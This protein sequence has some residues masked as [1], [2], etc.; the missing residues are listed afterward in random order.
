MGRFT[1]C[2]YIFRGSYLGAMVAIKKGT[3]GPKPSKPGRQ[4]IGTGSKFTEE[5]T[6][7]K[8]GRRV[9][10]P[11]VEVQEEDQFPT[12]PIV[13]KPQMGLEEAPSAPSKEVDSKINPSTE[14][15]RKEPLKKERIE[16]LS[17]KRQLKYQL[18]RERSQQ[19]SR[20][21]NS[22][23]GTL[24]C[25]RIGL[26]SHQ[27][28][29]ESLRINPAPKVVSKVEPKPL[30][31]MLPLPDSGE[32][33]S[34]TAAERMIPFEIKASQG[35]HYLVKLVNTDT[36]TDILT[37]FVRSGSTAEIDVPLGT[38]E[39]KFA[40]GEAWYGDKHL[41][42]PKTVC[43]K[44]DRTFKFDM[45]GDHLRGHSITLYKVPHGNLHISTIPPQSFELCT[46]NNHEQTP[47]PSQE[48]NL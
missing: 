31:P 3:K 15:V 7:S 12:G 45:V 10:G 1:M 36:H 35:S 8:P 21:E 40:C 37:V 11:G 43:S 5:I 2:D 46:S 41:F 13:W 30:I 27:E 18:V 6:S 48:L 28:S 4:V 17:L 39:V 33:V 22:L 32:V 44:V 25:Q 42:G 16:G 20:K 14:I 9:I 38:Y 26:R 47:S 19:I 24:K 23:L 34:F 29:R